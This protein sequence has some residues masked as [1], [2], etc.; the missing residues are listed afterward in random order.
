ME[1]NNIFFTK[2]L[3]EYPR[4]PYFEKTIIDKFIED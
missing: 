3:L 4:F 1:K 2:D